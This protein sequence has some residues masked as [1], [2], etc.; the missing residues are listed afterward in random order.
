MRRSNRLRMGKRSLPSAA[1]QQVEIVD[2][3][4]DLSDFPLDITPNP[5]ANPNPIASPPQVLEL[6]PPIV[7][8]TPKGRVKKSAPR[9]PVKRITPSSPENQVD[10]EPH[11][12]N[13][14]FPQPPIDTEPEVENQNSVPAEV[15]F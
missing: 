2:I 13:Q 6:P 3:E 4:D 11:T 14:A 7:K 9:T 15:G 1:T 8:R 5:I 12:E 10:S